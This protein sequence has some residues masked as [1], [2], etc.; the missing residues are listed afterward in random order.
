MSRSQKKLNCNI[1]NFQCGGRCM[2]TKLNCRKDNTPESNESKMLSRVSTL[3][4]KT[5]GATKPANKNPEI[6]PELKSLYRQWSK[7][8]DKDKKK[9]LLNL[10]K[11]LEGGIVSEPAQKTA[12]PK[13]PIPKQ[14]EAEDD[15]VLS[16][17]MTEEEQANYDKRLEEEKREDEKKA[18]EAKKKVG[19]ILDK[20]NGAIENYN[21]KRLAISKD[22]TLS[23][24]EKT[25]AIR[26]NNTQAY[27]VTSE[28]ILGSIKEEH[29]INDPDE[30]YDSADN[31]YNNNRDII[32]SL[33]EGEIMWGYEKALE[34]FGKLAEIKDLKL[35]V[36]AKRSNSDSLGTYSNVDKTISLTNSFGIQSTMIHEMAH[37]IEYKNPKV[38][39]KLKEKIKEIGINEYTQEIDLPED[40]VVRD[41]ANTIYGYKGNIEDI[42]ATEIFTVFFELLSQEELDGNMQNNVLLFM[43]EK[44]ELKEQIKIILEIL[45]G[46]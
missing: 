18:K 1:G 13:E 31:F 38:L 23:K 15:F 6:T 7:E 35:E 17:E 39:K 11:K 24:D 3:V 22:I 30:I 10:I 42:E 29:G 45:F 8:K 25:K 40:E 43:N 5:L 27:K 19:I 26:E 12:P 46:L 28:L 33:N 37:S 41:Y 44:G 16:F 21:K 34:N 36:L 14:P 4:N 9:E 32:K 2:S 20:F